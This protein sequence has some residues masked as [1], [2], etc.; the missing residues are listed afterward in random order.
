MVDGAAREPHRWRRLRQRCHLHGERV[1]DHS[2][3]HSLVGREAEET[4][5]DVR[6][7]L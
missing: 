2:W 6:E 3:R 5:A 4:I 1:A 7:R